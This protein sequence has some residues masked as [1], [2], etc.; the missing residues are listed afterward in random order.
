[1]ILVETPVLMLKKS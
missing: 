1:V